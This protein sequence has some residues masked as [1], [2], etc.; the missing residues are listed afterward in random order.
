VGILARPDDDITAWEGC[1]TRGKQDFDITAQKLGMLCK[2]K[3]P[4]V[5]VTQKNRESKK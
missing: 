1:S 3:F 4:K 5:Y 2:S